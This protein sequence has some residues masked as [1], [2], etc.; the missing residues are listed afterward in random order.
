MDIKSD[1]YKLRSECLLL[2]N[3][4]IIGVAETHL[5]GDQPIFSRIYLVRPEQDKTYKS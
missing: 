2:N 4:D 3:L 1:N 5:F